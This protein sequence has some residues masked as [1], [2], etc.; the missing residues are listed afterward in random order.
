MTTESS[1]SPATE[2][3]YKS[4]GWLI[5]GGILSLFVGFMAMGSPY[6]F[7]ILIAQL[8]GAFALASGIIS[9]ILVIFGKH[10]GHR[11]LDAISAL[12]RIAAGIVLLACVASSVAVIT[13]IFAI[14]LIVEG[15]LMTIGAFRMR[16]HPGWIWTLISGLAALILGIMV[17]YRWPSDSVWVLGFIFGINL[18]F[19]GISLLALGLSV[20]RQ[21][22]AAV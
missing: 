5:A 13:L 19:N 2:A 17:Y 7:S 8:L 16:D 15:V 12:I 22:N 20:P 6:L 18:L 21:K 1:L 11:I 3:L 4:R 9:L 14:F 10:P